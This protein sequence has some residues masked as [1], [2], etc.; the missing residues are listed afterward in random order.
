MKPW[1]STRMSYPG[2]VIPDYTIPA[3]TRINKIVVSG[4]KALR[5]SP[6]SA[7]SVMDV[8][9]SNVELSEIEL[10]RLRRIA[11]N[12]A[13]LR[14]LGIAKPHLLN[15]CNLSQGPKPRPKRKVVSQEFSVEK[16]VNPVRKARPQPLS[17]RIP[18]PLSSGD[19]TK[20]GSKGASES[21]SFTMS[22]S[23]PRTRLVNHSLLWYAEFQKKEDDFYA[24]EK[25]PF[26][27]KTRREVIDEL[28]SITIEDFKQNSSIVMM[29]VSCL[30][31]KMNVPG[32][33]TFWRKALSKIAGGNAPA[34]TVAVATPGL[35]S[36]PVLGASELRTPGGGSM[37][38]S[39]DTSVVNSKL[40]C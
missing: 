3:E 9:P 22:D 28:S 2:L 20:S 32:A 25:F 1:I 21:S 30:L 11:A 31:D 15:A 16:R 7:E 5:C 23:E 4:V 38:K 12:K 34:S 26:L 13:K 36:T 24:D 17:L 27:S 35:P 14:E 39:V 19:W 33:V 37:G 6:F 8:S 29:N 18:A 40:Y 10:Q